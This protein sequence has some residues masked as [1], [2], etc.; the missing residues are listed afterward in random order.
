MKRFAVVFAATGFTLIAIAL[1][2]ACPA[3]QAAQPSEHPGA[4]MQNVHDLAD[5]TLRA[6]L[7]SS[8]DHEILAPPDGLWRGS[9]SPAGAPA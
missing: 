6:V 8:G 4:L 7:I 1:F 3:H 2:N 9:F 5:T